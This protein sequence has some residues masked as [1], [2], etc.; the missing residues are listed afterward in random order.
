MKFL[1]RNTS[2]RTP[3]LVEIK[4]Q[5]ALKRMREQLFQQRKKVLLQ[6]NQLRMVRDLRN[7]EKISVSAFSEF[8]D[9][10]NLYNK[11]Y[12]NYIGSEMRLKE[13]H[14]EDLNLSGKL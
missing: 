8:R 14:H 1:N 4:K 13:V 10:L 12:T 5:Q 6:E 7:L 3:N 2:K 11:Y 9:Q